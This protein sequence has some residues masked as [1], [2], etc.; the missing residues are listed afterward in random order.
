VL[1]SPQASKFA[2][3]GSLDIATVNRAVKVRG[4]IPQGVETLR[5]TAVKDL[6][7]G[8]LV[9]SSREQK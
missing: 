1:S 7:V 6:S 3:I 9:V 2:F 8:E 5:K 4:L